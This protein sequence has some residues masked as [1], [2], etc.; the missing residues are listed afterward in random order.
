MKRFLLWATLVLIVVLTVASIVG[1][2]LGT[3]RAQAFFNS[4]PL[5]VYWMLLCLALLMGFIAFRRLRSSPPSFCIHAGC[6]AILCGGL[7]GSE[8]G[9]HLQNHILG[10]D[11]LPEGR[12]GLVDGQQVNGMFVSDGNEVVPL[13][14][15]VKLDRFR[16]EYYPGTLQVQSSSGEEAWQM[17]V[18]PNAVYDLSAYG[19]L[20][21]AQVFQNFKIDFDEDPNGA[22]RSYA[23]DDPGPGD[24]AALELYVT[25]PGGTPRRHFVFAHR[26]GHPRSGDS[27]AF[28]YKRTISD[29]ISETKIIKDGKVVAEKDIEVNHPLYYGGYHFYQTSFGKDPQSGMPYTVLSVVPNTGLNGVYLGYIL[30]CI[31]VAWQCWFVSLRKTKLG[32]GA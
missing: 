9:R 12:I 1:A 27:L 29:Y 17:T 26:A 20:H 10:R 4:P 30:L 18:E 23:Y 21:I 24:N 14:F 6:V 11:I 22:R 3:D 28:Q 16:I 31:G 25:P 5:A 2:F 15:T 8:T 19:A 13:P 32:E 7:W